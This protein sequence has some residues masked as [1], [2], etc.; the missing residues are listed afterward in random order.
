MIGTMV[1][2]AQVRYV[3]KSDLGFARQGLILVRNLSDGQ[4]DAPVSG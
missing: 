1:L 3:R 2:V 4:I